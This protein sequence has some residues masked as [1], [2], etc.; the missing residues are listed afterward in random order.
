MTN[1][2][3]EFEPSED[4]QALADLAAKI[5][6][7]MATT[8][9]VVQVEEEEGGFDR[10]LWRTLADSGL[11]AVALPEAA[12]GGDMGILG[13]ITLAEQQ[14][15]RV[16]PVPFWSVVAGAALPLAEFGTTELKER[17]LK[18]LLSG[19]S[20][21]TAALEGVAGQIEVTG[22]VDG[23]DL[24][25]EGSVTGVPVAVEADAVLVPVHLED[26][27]IRVVVVPTDAAGFSVTSVGSTARGAMGTIHLDGVRVPATDVLV[28]DGARIRQWVLQR[29]RLALCGV[30]VGTCSEALKSTAAYVSQREQFGRPLSTNQAVAVRAADA[31]LDTEAIRVTTQRAAWLLDQGREEEA[32]AAVL[33]AKF[34]AS[35]GGLRAVHATQHLHGGIGA[36]VSY[37][38]HRYFLWGRQAAFSLGGAH[39]VA[40]EL[41]DVL[42]DAPRIGA[43]L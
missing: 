16:A 33:V 34:W 9:R 35:R 40:S 10:K 1:Q 2:P 32:V 22:R 31:Y 42:L 19:Q 17:W 26:Q 41:G 12:G 39:Q 36:D 5:F 21:V 18:P 14:G 11:L 43:S 28:G 20:L 4:H 7:D 13:L 3:M 15:R 24:V 8:D 37:P 23:D 6:A 25:I 30:Q 27:S 38:I 29:A